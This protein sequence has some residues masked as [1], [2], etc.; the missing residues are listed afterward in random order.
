M[1]LARFAALVTMVSSCLPALAASNSD[2][3]FLGGNPQ[4]Q[5][6]YAG[7][8]IN[9]GNVGSLGVLWYADLPIKEGLVSNPLVRDGVIYQS[10]PRG[11]ALATDVATGKT[12][13][14]YGPA[15]NFT[16]YSPASATVAHYTRG[17]GIDDEHLYIG[18]GCELIALNRRTGTNWNRQSGRSLG[19]GGSAPG[20]ADQ[21]M[22]YSD[23]LIAPDATTGGYAWHFQYLKGDLWDFS[24]GAAHIVLADLPSSG[25]TRHVVMQAAKNGFFYLFDA[26]TGAFISANNYVPVKNY[27][28][29][30]PRTG[31]LIVRDDLR[32]P[33]KGAAPAVVEPDG[34]GSAYLGVDVLQSKDRTRIHPRIHFSRLRPLRVSAAD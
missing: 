14:T 25:G 20:L 5:Q 28:P 32:H 6:Y 7:D 3:P 34:V 11:G 22:L 31:E 8:Q 29:M 10:V 30:D 15:F 27:E 33:K 17:F 18:A 12:L 24:D 13:W 21:P 1:L 16:G 23:S 19:E 9:S 4:S 26:K 2:W